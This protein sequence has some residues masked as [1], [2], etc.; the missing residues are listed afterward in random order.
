M[1]HHRSISLAH[2]AVAEHVRQR[3]QRRQQLLRITGHGRTVL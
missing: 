3:R 1:T 2:V